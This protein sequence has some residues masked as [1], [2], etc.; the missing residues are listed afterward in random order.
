MESGG[1]KKPRIAD[2]SLLRRI[3]KGAYGEVWLARNIMGAWRAIKIVYRDSFSNPRPFEREFEG[4]QKFE[5]ISRIDESQVDVL[6]V[7]RSSDDS[8]FFYIME[9]ADDELTGAVINP[10]SYVPRTLRS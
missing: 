6:H 5:P 1:D 7:G 4:I 2:H 3:G 10:E 8:F 9:L